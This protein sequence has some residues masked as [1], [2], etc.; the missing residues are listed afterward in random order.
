M[1]LIAKRSNYPSK[2][3]VLQ[4][5]ACDRGHDSISLY[6]QCCQFG[7]VRSIY[8]S[9]TLGESKTANILFGNFSRDANRI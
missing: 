9:P 7:I 8:Y 2:K 6:I 1:F 4:N 3:E 5:Y